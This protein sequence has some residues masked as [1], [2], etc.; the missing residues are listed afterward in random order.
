MKKFIALVTL[1]LMSGCGTVQMVDFDLQMISFQPFQTKYDGKLYS[2]IFDYNL[3]AKGNEFGTNFRVPLL[4]K[5]LT[6][7]A[8]NQSQVF[9]EDSTRQIEVL[10][11]VNYIDYVLMVDFI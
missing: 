5:D 8:L 7:S 10:V 3:P 11:T 6:S 2:L 1:L 9:R 4:W